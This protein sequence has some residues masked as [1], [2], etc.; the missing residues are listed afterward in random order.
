MV[1]LMNNT[2]RL[3]DKVFRVIGVTSI[4]FCLLILAIFIAFI[5][6]QGGTRLSWEFMISLPSRF[7]EKSGIYTAWVGTL[8]VLILTTFIAFPLGVGAGIYLEEYS[9]KN[10]LSKLLEINTA[11]LR[12]ARASDLGMVGWVVC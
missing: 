10:W 2:N 4:I 1:R 11:N 5:I 7:A 8:W 9:P 12:G 3:K 6:Y